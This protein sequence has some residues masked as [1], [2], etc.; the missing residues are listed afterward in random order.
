MQNDL[1]KPRP[2][3]QIFL[4]LALSVVLVTAC[5]S[6]IVGFADALHFVRP[7]VK[8]LTPMHGPLESF[9]KLVPAGVG[10][11]YY[12]PQ[13]C[14][15]FRLRM[16]LANS[17]T[18]EVRAS[19]LKLGAESSM[20]AASLGMSS[21]D[22]QTASAIATSFASYGLTRDGNADAAQVR[23]E[24]ELIQPLHEAKRKKNAWI[25][26]FTFYFKR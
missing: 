25:P 7:S 18:G 1:D 2:R 10:Y 9:S 21:Q 15:E 22:A 6:A 4:A 23:L 8:S 5:Y 17:K 19:T 24:A 13:V 3:G 14:S 26:L 20:I 16:Q 12:A 11:G